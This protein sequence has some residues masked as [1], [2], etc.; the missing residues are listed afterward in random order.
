M[1]VKRETSGLRLETD[2]THFY[3]LAHPPCK[4]RI[5]NNS[6]F[7]D[8]SLFEKFASSTRSFASTGRSFYT[9]KTLYT[10]SC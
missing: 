2:T 3:N 9:S 1:S 4:I 10:R 7:L 6:E 5:A 8:F